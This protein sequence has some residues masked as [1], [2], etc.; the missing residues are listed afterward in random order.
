M[1]QNTNAGRGFA[2]AL[3]HQLLDDGE[4]VW[5]DDSFSSG[6]L[7]YVSQFVRTKGYRLR[8]HKEDEGIYVW[9]EW[10]GTVSTLA[11]MKTGKRG[12]HVQEQERGV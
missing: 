4:M 2:P 7:G 10:T 1:S 12:A 8:T 6:R 9:L 3:L 11:E 5:L